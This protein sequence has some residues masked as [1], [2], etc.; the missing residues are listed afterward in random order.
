VTPS[1]LELAK[2][3][4]TPYGK[5]RALRQATM[6]RR[7]SEAE[8]RAQAEARTRVQ[9]ETTAPTVGRERGKR[10]EKSQS[11]VNVRRRTVTATKESIEE[12]DGEERETAEAEEG[13][14]EESP[15]PGKRLTN[16]KDFYKLTK[17]NERVDEEKEKEEAPKEEDQKN[18]VEDETTSPCKEAA[19]ESPDGGGEVFDWVGYSKANAG[20]T[21]FCNRLPPPQQFGHGNPFLM[22]LSL[23]CLLQ[24]REHIMRTQL[25]YQDIA[26][27]FD[28]LVRSHQ[29]DRVL[30]QARRLFAEYL[31]EDWS[32]SPQPNT[33]QA[34]TC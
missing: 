30:G 29:V 32:P 18:K 23:A 13:G 2:P 22:F 1:S 31:N 24:H 28:R 27:F 20:L 26:M 25:D 15:P 8:G 7:N 11:L 5:V 10:C 34:H 3:C 9:S 6:E 14:E 19:P 33:G 16:L 21:V 12:R 4:E 17:E